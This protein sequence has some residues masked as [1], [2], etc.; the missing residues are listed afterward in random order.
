MVQAA[1][2]RRLRPSWRWSFAALGLMWGCSYWW[3]DLGLRSL[4]PIDVAFGR[5]ALGAATLVAILAVTHSRLPRD[6]GTWG[7][8]VVLGAFFNAIP[9]TS[10]AFGETHV[11]SDLAGLLNSLTPLA[12]LVVSS[13]AF[14][15]S[16]PSARVLAGVALGLA[17]VIVI[18][19]AWNGIG[20]GELLGTG[21]C[22]VTVASFGVAFSYSARFLTGSQHPPVVLAAGQVLC[23]SALLL[24]FAI[25]LGHVSHPLSSSVIFGMLAL[26]I[27]STGIAYVLNFDVARNTSSTTASTVTY[28][29]PVVAVGVGA[30]FLGEAV[31][32]NDVVGGAL[33]LVGAAIAQIGP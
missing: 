3:I 27:L 29:M 14:R 6:R 20:H 4:S 15:Q 26:G 7:H 11:S 10:L 22:L 5:V 2:G 17:G 13:L 16:K 18:V 8:L 31:T 33:V 28:L 9:F 21:A 32:G 25:T 12:T 1:V 24:P 30:A 19:G 23:G